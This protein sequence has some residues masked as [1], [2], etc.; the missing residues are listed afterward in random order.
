[1][2][3][4]ND[5]EEYL[6]DRVSPGKNFDLIPAITPVKNTKSYPIGHS[7][8]MV[9]T[10]N[11]MNE[12]A[13]QTEIVLVCSSLDPEKMKTVHNF[14]NKFGAKFEN[15]FS[16]RIT[17]VIVSSDPNTKVCNKTFKYIQGIAYN[18][19][20]ISF[21]WIVDCLKENRLLNEDDAK[22]EVLDPDVLE[23]GSTKSRTMSRKLFE[24]FAMYC[25]GPFISFSLKEF[26]VSVRYI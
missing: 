7:T 12:S 11:V 3:Q 13:I 15:N 25:L 18:K 6:Q 21:Q 1:M 26:K 10:T 4:K 8:P 2:A 5:E 22:Y 20:V 23:P 9:F 17:H 19:Y 16:T 14:V 24:G